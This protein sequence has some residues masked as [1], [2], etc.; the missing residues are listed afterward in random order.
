MRLVS[1]LILYP[2]VCFVAL[3]ANIITI[4]VFTRKKLKSS[5]SIFLLN[6]AISDI[7]KICNDI[8]YFVSILL[9]V[10]SP[11]IGKRVLMFIYPYAHYIFNSSMTCAAWL[12][13]AVAIERYLLVCHSTQAKT[14]CTIPRALI[15]SNAIA[16]ASFATSTPYL[17]KYQHSTVF[18]S[19]GTLHILEISNLWKNDMF[20]TAFNIFHYVFRSVV[21][22]I[23]LVVYSLLIIRR[24]RQC[25]FKH[26]KRRT[27][28]CLL[29]VIISF[30]I[31][32]TPDTVLS[33]VL[34]TGYR[35]ASYL[36]RGIRE[37]TDFLLLLNTGSNFIIY[38][39]LNTKFCKTLKE[40]VTRRGHSR[41]L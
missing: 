32:A 33:A 10:I 1:G 17:F 11:D 38:S 40:I 15:L 37:I 34:Q 16:F 20:S 13:V 21:P 28:L 4:V 24:L 6:L 18:A 41:K 36:I 25:R 35:E 7:I 29:M 19:N 12:I 39:A 5:T 2:L 26:R 3:P 22:I 27:V 30:V 31:C 9:T 23:L 14:I 8:M